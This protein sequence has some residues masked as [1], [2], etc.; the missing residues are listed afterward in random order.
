[1]K[2]E[3]STL[4]RCNAKHQLAVK[5]NIQIF[6][7]SQTKKTVKQTLSRYK[8]EDEAFAGKRIKSFWNQLKATKFL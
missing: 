4:R 3:F 8:S 7:N 5:Q 2:N 6:E 1:M